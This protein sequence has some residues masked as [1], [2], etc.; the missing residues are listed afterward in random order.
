[1]RS[2]KDR[3]GIPSVKAEF[4]KNEMKSMT[5]SNEVDSLS[6]YSLKL[7]KTASPSITK[8]LISDD[9]NYLFAYK[10]VEKRKD[11]DLVKED[12]LEVWNLHPKKPSFLG[13]QIN[14]LYDFFMIFVY[15]AGAAALILFVIH[16]WLLKKMH[17]VR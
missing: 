2:V 7:I 16:K 15:M 9:G 4:D 13:M 11:K 3:V 17:G 1:S 10:Q 8:A 14:T 6:M 12:R 5:L